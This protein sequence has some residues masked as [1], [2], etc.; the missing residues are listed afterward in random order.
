MV[1]E[2]DDKP[3]HT[4]CPQKYPHSK[5]EKRNRRYLMTK[6]LL[7]IKTLQVTMKK[8]RLSIFMITDCS[9]SNSHYVYRGIPLW[10]LSIAV[11]CCRGAVLC[12]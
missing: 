8:D 6:S 2:R 1:V 7:F 5:T 10:G 11:L 4:A 3:T 12:G 9:S